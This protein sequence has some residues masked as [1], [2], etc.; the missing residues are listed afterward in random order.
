[1]P[2]VCL[3]RGDEA[4]E[5][6][7]DGRCGMQAGVDLQVRGRPEQGFDRCDLVENAVAFGC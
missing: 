5:L 1:M 7:G 4:E 3:G 2:F 6:S